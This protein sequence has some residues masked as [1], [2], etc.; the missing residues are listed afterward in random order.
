MSQFCQQLNFSTG[1]TDNEYFITVVT[2][3]ESGA[4]TDGDV[5]VELVG[6]NIRA[7]YFDLNRPGVSDFERN[8]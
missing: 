7:Q 8:M 6:D 2:A 4:G 1:G 3:D 5:S